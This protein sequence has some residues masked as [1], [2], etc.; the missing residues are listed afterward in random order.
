MKK[1]KGLDKFLK[2][3]FLEWLNIE[4]REKYRM[5]DSA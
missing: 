4:V 2:D 1:P 3:E 5:S